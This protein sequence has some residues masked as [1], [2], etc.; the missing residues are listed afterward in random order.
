[1]PGA[2]VK[3]RFAGKDLDGFVRRAGRAHRPHRHAD[4]AA[5]GGQPRAGAAPGRRRA[6]RRCSPSATPAPAPTCS[7]WPSRPGTPPPRSSRRRPRSRSRSTPAAAARPGRRYPAAD[8]FLAPPADGRL[9]ACGVVGRCP[10]RTGRAL[11][12]A[13]A[14]ATLAGGRG[15]LLV[16]ARPPRRRPARRRADRRARR[17]APR[18]A[19]RRR[20]ARRGATASSSPSSRGTRRIVVGTRA[21]AFAPVHDLGLV[22]IWDDGDDLH[23]E[24]RAPYPHAREVLLSRAQVE[25]AARAGRRLRPQRRG[26]AAA[27]PPAGPTSSSRPARRCAPRS[28]VRSPAP[29]TS[30]S[31]ATRSR[32]RARMP[33]QVARRDRRRRS[34]A[35]PVLRPD[36]APRLRRRRWPASAAVRRPGAPPAPARSR[37]PG[38][39]RPRPAGGAA[40]S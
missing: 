21:A 38:A 10:G 14:A 33:K 7:G 28:R 34:S 36:P 31:S 17:R 2:R 32:G 23:A 16:R 27:S 19:H 35:G 3:V 1:M 39:P 20:R 4:P 26:R 11:L 37:S 15:A 24:P 8:A 22:A 40:R 25:D 12:A 30:S 6:R 13:A 5:P 18:R 29:P 9:A